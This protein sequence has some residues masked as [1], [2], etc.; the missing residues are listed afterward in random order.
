M[1]NH[2]PNESKIYLKREK[3][4]ITVD[5]E[6]HRNYDRMNDTY[7][8]RKQ[9]HKCCRCPKDKSWL[10]DSDCENCEFKC[11][12]EFLSLDAVINPDSDSDPITLG[13]TISDDKPSIE[14]IVADKQLLNALFAE[15]NELDPDMR[16]IVELT[17][18]GKSE[19]EIAAITGAP[20]QS[21]VNYRK[22]KAFQALQ[23]RMKKHL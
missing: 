1:E 16:Q 14:E 18:D 3:R 23:E 13:D 8:H 12:S 15:L 20:T 21:T 6:V 7:R 9:A 17:L 4:W 2:G 5:Q 10:C 19:R 11:G 22:K